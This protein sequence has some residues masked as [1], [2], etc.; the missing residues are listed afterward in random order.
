VTQNVRVLGISGSLRQKSYNTAALHAAI[1]L[2]PKSMSVEIASIRDIPLY[3]QDVYDKEHPAAATRFREQCKAADAILFV[4]PEYNYSVPGALKNAID[5]ASRK[6]DVP[7]HG[8][9]C[10][11]MGATTGVLGTA[12]CQYHLRQILVSMDMRAVNQPEVMIGSAKTKFDDELTLID[13]TT[14]ELIQK[15]MQALHD[16]TLKLR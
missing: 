1:A 10:A 7:L 9:P 5:W 3:D 8:K 11:I 13:K 4:T 12:R 15:L 2:A 16:L 14:G 6:P